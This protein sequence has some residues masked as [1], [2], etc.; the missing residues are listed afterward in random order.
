M[1]NKS[2]TEHQSLP[3]FYH[4]QKK[5]PRD[6]QFHN[7]LS[8]VSYYLSKEHGVDIKSMYS[9]LMGKPLHVH[10]LFAAH[11]RLSNSASLPSSSSCCLKGAESE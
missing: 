4:S 2:E 7:V 10:V 9:A 8:V 5:Q 11:S 6:Q 1:S 3:V